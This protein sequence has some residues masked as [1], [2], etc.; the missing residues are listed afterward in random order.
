[1]S[2]EIFFNKR[3]TIIEDHLSDDNLQRA[4]EIAEHTKINFKEDYQKY[5]SGYKL[6]YFLASIITKTEARKKIVPN[7]EHINEITK[8]I[9][10]YESCLELKNELPEAHLG[11]GMTYRMISMAIGN[12][13]EGTPEN[14]KRLLYLTNQGIKHLEIAKKLRSDYQEMANRNLDDLITSRDILISYIN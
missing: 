6:D 9:N 2:K 3:L 5:D 11:L 4:K 14:N 13:F 12:M 7:K 10:L 8:A 1:M